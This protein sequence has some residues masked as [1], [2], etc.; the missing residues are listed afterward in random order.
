MKAEGFGRGRR[1]EEGCRGE[2]CRGLEL[3]IVVF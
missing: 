3:Y 1:L 2:G